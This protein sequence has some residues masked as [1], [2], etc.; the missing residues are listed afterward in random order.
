MCLSS[1][2]QKS[3]VP[4][5]LFPLL[6]SLFL[7]SK[8]VKH[9]ICFPRIYISH[10]HWKKKKLWTG[11]DLSAGFLRA[12]LLQRHRACVRMERRRRH[13]AYCTASSLL[14][15]QARDVSGGTPPP[16]ARTDS[17]S[18]S[19]TQCWFFQVLDFMT[20]WNT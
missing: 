6:S 10:G 20:D 15:A 16:P 5:G 7:N 19:F 8:H 11:A 3:L 1:D 14:R 4:F 18:V 13:S 2:E 9:C 12:S 17:P